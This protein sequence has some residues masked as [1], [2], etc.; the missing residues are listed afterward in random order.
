[1]RG[2][3]WQRDGEL[4]EKTNSTPNYAVQSAQKINHVGHTQ[5]HTSCALPIPSHGH[6]GFSE[7]DFPV[8]DQIKSD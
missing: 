3:A 6:S 8:L 5:Y 2:V 1:M 4:T 7:G